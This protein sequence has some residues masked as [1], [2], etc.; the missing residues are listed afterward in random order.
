MTKSGPLAV[1][2]DLVAVRRHAATL[3]TL[4]LRHQGRVAEGNNP[5]YSR[6]LSD[7]TG[8]RKIG[9]AFQILFSA[10]RCC[11]VSNVPR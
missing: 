11:C 1:S 4:Q 10:N 9:E 7:S 2:L 3:R 8:T 6:S 5:R